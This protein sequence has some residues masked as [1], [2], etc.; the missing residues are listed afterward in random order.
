[1]SEPSSTG[2]EHDDA[3]S[4]EL[5]RQRKKVEDLRKKHADT[6][7]AVERETAILEGLLRAARV[8]GLEAA[9]PEAPRRRRG[10]AVARRRDAMIEVLRGG[11]MTPTDLHAEVQSKIGEDAGERTHIQDQLR[12]GTDLFR[13]LG[14]GR[15]GLAGNQPRASPPPAVPR[16]LINPV[17]PPPVANGRTTPPPPPRAAPPPAQRPAP[18]PPRPRAAAPA[19]QAQPADVDFD[20]PTTWSTDDETPF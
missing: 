18:P 12:L 9:A 16:I 20:L 2:G 3:L 6:G 1:M 15:W 5:A 13:P 4:Q 10:G 14:D 17:A 19:P 11:P 8:T 7:R